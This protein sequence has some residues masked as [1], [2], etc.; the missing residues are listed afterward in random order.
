MKNVSQQPDAE[1]YYNKDK[2][3]IQFLNFSHKKNLFFKK[4]TVSD[5]RKK[6][7][8]CYYYYNQCKM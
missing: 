8:I 3:K 6:G 5:V 7:Q 4:K 1:I 2:N